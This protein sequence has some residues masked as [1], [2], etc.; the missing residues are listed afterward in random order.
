M[1]F[2]VRLCGLGNRRAKDLGNAAICLARMNTEF[3]ILNLSY[4]VNALLANP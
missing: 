4:L 1:Y 2:G 3:V